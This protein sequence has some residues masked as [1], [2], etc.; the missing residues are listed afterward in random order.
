M[1]GRKYNANKTALRAVREA[2]N[3]ACRAYRIRPVLNF[4]SEGKGI[5]HYEWEQ[6]KKKT[7]WKQQIRELIDELIPSVRNLNEL[8][9]ML[10]ERGFEIKRA[11]YISIKA[12]GQERFIRTKTLGEEYTEESLNIRILYSDVDTAVEPT[13]DETS[14]LWDAY[15]SIIGDVRILAGQSRKVPRKQNMILPYSADNELDVFS[16]V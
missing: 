6:R 15:S 13:P 2:A 11:K 16:E 14:K 5:S 3:T 12:P 8:W 1:S 10:K 4:G 9:E 7:S